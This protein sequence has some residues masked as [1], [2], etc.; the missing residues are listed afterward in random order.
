MSVRTVFKKLHAALESAKVPYMVT[1][2]FASSAHGAPRA[3]NDI[4]VV[5]APTREQLL[6][7]LEHF[8]ESGYYSNS[9][10]ALGGLHNRSQFNVID[11]GG[12]W[13]ID[14]IFRKDREFSEHEFSRRTIVEIA[15]VPLYAA[16]PEDVLISKLEWAKFGQSERQIDDAAGVIR[17]QANN[18][19]LVYIRTWVAKLGL[20]H[21]WRIASVKA[22]HW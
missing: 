10:E 18:L 21:E 20:E 19:D 6:A 7:L 16:T 5:I 9:E 4:D 2:S 17:V 15:G 1:G 22:E 14:F 11:Y 12:L 13:K 8:P 3:T